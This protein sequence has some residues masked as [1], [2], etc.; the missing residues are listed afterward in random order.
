MSGFPGKAGKAEAIKA[1]CGTVAKTGRTNMLDAKAAFEIALEMGFNELAD[2]IFMDTPGY[3]KL[4][5]TGEL[6]DKDLKEWP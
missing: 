5:I 2:F 4:M 3:S 6:D 1:Q